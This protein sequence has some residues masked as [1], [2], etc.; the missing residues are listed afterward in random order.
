MIYNSKQIFEKI[1]QPK[2]MFHYIIMWFLYYY[3]FF[4]NGI[5]KKYSNP[6]K[7]SLNIK[8]IDYVVIKVFLNFF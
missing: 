2:K 7:T 3:Y 6:L 1:L 8:N 4:K 5:F